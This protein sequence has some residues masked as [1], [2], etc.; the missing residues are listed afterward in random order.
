MFQKPLRLINGVLVV[1]LLLVVY[2]FLLLLQTSQWS[3]LLALAF[4]LF[5]NN[6]VLFKV[7]RDRFILDKVH[8]TG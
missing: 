6:Y 4:L 7:A 5:S 3:H 2:Q 1:T 8:K